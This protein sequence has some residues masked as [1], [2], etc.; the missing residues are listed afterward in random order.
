MRAM[1]QSFR[2]DFQGTQRL[3][4][5]SVRRAASENMQYIFLAQ[6]SLTQSDLSAPVSQV[7]RNSLL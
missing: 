4:Q 3:G 7:P 1:P 6:S 2:H 5:G